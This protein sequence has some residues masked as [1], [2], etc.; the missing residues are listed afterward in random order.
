M[1]NK[2]NCIIIDDEPKMVELLADMLTDLYPDIVIEGKFTYWKDALPAIRSIRPQILFMDISMP[3]KTGFDLLELIPN[4]K[5]QVI[6]VTAHTEFAINAFDFDVC[7][8]VLKP[9]TDRSLVKAVDRALARISDS[10][11]TVAQSGEKIGIPDDHGI[12]YVEIESIIC[13]ES[14]NRYTKVVTTDGEILSSYNL[15]KFQETFS[16]DQFFQVHRSCVVNLKYVKR[17]D[18]SGTIYLSNG[19]QIPLSG[20]FKENFL[21]QFSRIGK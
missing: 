15:G 8:Y 7:G 9:V 1:H 16:P 6:F 19:M 14:V 13:L 3:E 5:A 21:Q 12:R 10:G 2:T 11:A 4:H 18:R 17:Y 20:T